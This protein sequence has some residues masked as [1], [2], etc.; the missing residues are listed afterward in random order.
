MVLFDCM[1]QSC[2]STSVLLVD[3]SN[4]NVG[5][6]FSN[7]LVKS[8]FTCPNQ[9]SKGMSR[10]NYNSFQVQKLISHNF[11][12]C[13]DCIH[14]SCVSKEILSVDISYAHFRHK[15]LNSFIQSIFNSPHQ[16]S[17]IVNSTISMC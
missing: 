13:F 17:F 2:G 9:T 1:H 16:T 7:N 8:I 6:K 4:V 12:L 14:Q 3:C 11:I 10:I 15:S 5:Q